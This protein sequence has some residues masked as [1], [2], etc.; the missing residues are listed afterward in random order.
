VSIT[1]TERLR[2]SCGTPVEVTVADSLNAGRHPHLKQAVLDRTLHTFQCD[3][4]GR[5]VVLEKDLCYFDF[6]RRQFFACYPRHER[7]REAELAAEVK[8]AHRTWMGEHAPAF[9]AEL[10]RSFLVRVCFGYEELREKIA[11]DDSGLADLVIEALKIDVLTADPWFEANQVV[12]LRFDHVRADGAL[13][14]RPEWL[15][16]DATRGDRVVD[17]SRALYDEIDDQFDQILQRRPGLARD[18]HVSLLRL[19]SWPDLRI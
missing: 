11:I 17:V 9:I 15:A 18:A 1:R 13:R 6:D 7:A 12:T 19:V 14:F 3:A 8:L 2:C 10:G 5:Q 4:C 16:P